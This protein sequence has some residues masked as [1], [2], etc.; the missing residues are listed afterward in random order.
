MNKKAGKQLDL[1]VHYLSAISNLKP[2]CRRNAS[3][4]WLKAILVGFAIRSDHEGVSSL[5]RTWNFKDNSYH[6]FLRAFNGNGLDLEKLTSLWTSQCLDELFRDS[7]VTLNGR[8]ILIGDGL[9]APKEGR[10]MPGVRLH[11]QDSSQNS[12][13]EF[14]MAHGFQCLSLL[15]SNKLGSVLSVPLRLRI[16]SG[17]KRGP[18]DSETGFDKFLRLVKDSIKK[19]SYLVLDALYANKKMVSGLLEQGHQIISKAARN[20]VAYQLPQKTP[21]KKEV[22]RP[23]QYGD[24]IIFAEEFKKI[25]TFE[26]MSSPYK[27]EKNIK[28]QYKCMKLLS[29]SIKIPLQFVLVKHP[30]KGKWILVTSD[31]TLTPNEVIEMYASRSKIE[32]MFKSLVHNVG[33]FTY[34]FWKKTMPLIKKGSGD[35]F[36]HRKSSEFKEKYEKKIQAFHLYVQSA[37]ISMGLLQHLSVIKRETIWDG[38]NSWM[39]TLN[40]EKTPSEQVVGSSL[41]GSFLEFLESNH[42]NDAFRKFILK[43]RRDDWIGEN[44]SAA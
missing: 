2:A 3:F 18:R 9:T 40:P 25:S 39:R 36:L 31:L 32:A 5:M 14:V 42:L 20:A 30:K 21:S 35:F 1:W 6:R 8:D 33:A 37:S 38:F 11:H 13:R 28:I 27:N 12:K 23:R 43:N 16:T 19:P 26:K 4:H 41:R 17:T 22:G 44:R 15:V 7:K 34:R 10:R 24:K 29:K